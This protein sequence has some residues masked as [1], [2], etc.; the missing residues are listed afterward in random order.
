[1]RPPREARGGHGRD[2][3]RAGTAL[4]GT[5]ATGTGEAGTSEAEERAE[6]DDRDYVQSMVRGLEVIRVFGRLNP[7]MTLSEVAHQTDMT[8]AAARRFLLTLVK[9]GYAETDGKYFSLRP[10]VL[11]LGFAYLSSNGIAEAAQAAMRDVVAG[12]GESCSAAVLDG[13]DIVY[14]CRVPSARVLAIGLSVGSRLPAYCT[15]MGR[16]L[17]AGL[18]EDRRAAF[19]E[20]TPIARLTPR[21]VPDRAALARAVEEAARQG[22]AAVDQE[23]EEGLRS[24]AVPVRDASGRVAAAINASV[25]AGRTTVEEL[26]ER[27]LPVLLEASA[28]ITASLRAGER[29]P[30]QPA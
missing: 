26:R 1:M 4:S 28:R 23:L 18:P 17:V 11:E 14:V 10:R 9:E 6:P 12:T 24:I 5:D 19:L 25:H 20:R 13:D 29:G 2:I 22:W 8:R 21:T 27:V 16:V 30:A 15:A 7:R 3:R